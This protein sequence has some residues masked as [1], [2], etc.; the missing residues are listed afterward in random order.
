MREEK[1]I[2][3]WERQEPQRSILSVKIIPPS[4]P[5]SDPSS[6]VAICVHALHWQVSLL[7]NDHAS[8]SR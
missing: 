3:K 2:R 6:N 1:E 7:R 4:L 8:E 5:S